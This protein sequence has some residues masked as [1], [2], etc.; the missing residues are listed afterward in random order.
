VGGRVP[1]GPEEIAAL[2]PEG[3]FIRRLQAD[4]LAIM[5]LLETGAVVKAG[6][7]VHRLAGAAGTFGFEEVGTIALTLDE[8]VASGALLPVEGL[9]RLAGA[10]ERA[11]GA[12]R[13]SG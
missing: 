9:V 1:P 4:H 7:I 11:V 10:L 12:A 2:D 8:A 5:R 13:K 6:P 3:H